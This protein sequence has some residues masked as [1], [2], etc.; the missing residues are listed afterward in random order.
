MKI[1]ITGANGML[2]TALINK[3]HLKHKIYATSRSNGVKREQAEWDFFDLLDFETLHSWL[4][5]KNMD[6]IIHCAAMIDVD[7]CEIMPEIAT[8]L[9]Y[10]TTKII[11]SHLQKTD[12]MLVYI[13]TDSV[14]DG[15]KSTPYTEEDGTRPLNIY[16][17]TKLAG[18]NPV[19]GMKNGL[20]IR[21]NIIGRS[22]S[23]KL[24]FA[25]WV[26]KGLVEKKK[27]NLFDD[28]IFSPLHVSDLSDLIHTLIDQNIVGLYNV[29]SSTS[30]SKYEFGLMMAD[31]FGLENR[32]IIK[33]FIKDKELVADRPCNMSL[34]SVK[35][36]AVLNK[37]MSTPE[38]SIQLLKQQYDKE[39]NL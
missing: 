6:I 37:K 1:G 4:D 14:F 9:H 7:K 30:L 31:I 28:V 32:F 38:Q 10:K 23:E 39:C 17:K 36:S 20:V 16:A 12:G 8:E 18:E 13:S 33:K 2:G 27:L 29:A 3:L 25:E 21:T 34:S 15:K 26:L 19:L 24:S 35:V 11:S 22:R 5:G